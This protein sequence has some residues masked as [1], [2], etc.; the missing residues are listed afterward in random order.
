MNRSRLRARSKRRNP[1]LEAQVREAVFARDG[2]CLLASVGPCAGRLSPHHRRK[3]A[4]GG[5]YVEAN[6]ATLCTYHNGL[7]EDEPSWFVDGGQFAGLGLV[8]REGDPEWS[9]LGRRANR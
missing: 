1:E 6:L 7:I 4:A 8:V 5:A 2:G 9:E 3:A